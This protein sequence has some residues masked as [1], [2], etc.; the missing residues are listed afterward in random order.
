MIF[1]PERITTIGSPKSIASLTALKTK[2]VQTN[3]IKK[4]IKNVVILGPR[5][6]TY[7]SRLG[8]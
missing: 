7:T 4:V 5:R 1:N 2:L 6:L 3:P 8:S